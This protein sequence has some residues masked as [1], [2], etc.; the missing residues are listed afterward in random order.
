MDR[1]HSQVYIWVEKNKNIFKILFSNINLDSVYEHCDR[2]PFHYV[3]LNSEWY[4]ETLYISPRNRILVKK[5]HVLILYG[6][7]ILLRKV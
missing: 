6:C 3:T 4:Y 1:N 2:M 5:K 7:H